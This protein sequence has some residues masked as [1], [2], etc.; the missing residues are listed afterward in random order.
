MAILTAV[1]AQLAAAA[2]QHVEAGA[3]VKTAQAELQKASGGDRHPFRSRLAQAEFSEVAA[4]RQL[5]DAKAAHDVA[6]TLKPKLGMLDLAITAASKVD[7]ELTASVL[8]ALDGVLTKLEAA[9][10]KFAQV[11]DTLGGIPFGARQQMN[12]G[13]PEL[14]WSS[15]APTRADV[16]RAVVLV[17]A[18]QQA[19]AFTAAP[20]AD[21]NFTPNAG[22]GF[23]DT[24]IEK[25]DRT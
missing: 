25:V 10:P 14:V 18:R 22:K 16:L 12:L 15:V 17:L 7:Q 20:P 2:K 5:D 19:A 13:A 24:K 23:G 8:A 11:R 6:E 1:A 4:R 21:Y 3:A 9:Q